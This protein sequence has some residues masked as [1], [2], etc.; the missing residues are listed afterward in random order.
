MITYGMSNDAVKTYIGQQLKQMRINARINQ[1]Q[2]AESAGISRSAITAIE[3]GHIGNFD[4]LL[5]ML[6]ALQKLNV[7]DAFATEAMVSPLLIAQTSG[8]TIKRIHKSN[9]K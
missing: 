7:L 3:N 6:R 5:N 4:S 2:L 1:E 8:K 9:K